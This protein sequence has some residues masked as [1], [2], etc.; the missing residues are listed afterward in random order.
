M[1]KEEKVYKTNTK[2]IKKLLILMAIVLVVTILYEPAKYLII[3]ATLSIYEGH[4]FANSNITMKLPKAYKEVIEEDEDY[5]I[6]VSGVEGEADVKVNQEYL[7][8][9]PQKLYK[10]VNVLNGI[11]MVVT[12]KEVPKKTMLTP[13]ELADRYY[14]LVQIY[15]EDAQIGEP[16]WEAVN[17]LGTEG[18][19]VFVDIDDKTRVGYLI[20]LDNSEL[21]IE[22]SGTKENV[23]KYKNEIEKIVENIKMK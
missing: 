10:G 9:L 13:E 3:R 1:K 21:T 15:F 4:E 16:I 6:N 19:K 22:F 2:I 14:V 23:E 18:A 8:T 20:P 11:S 17:I 12:E 7:N 5:Q